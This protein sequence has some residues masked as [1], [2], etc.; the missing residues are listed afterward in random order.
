MPRKK[1]A[2]DIFNA[3]ED[4]FFSRK[5]QLF[6]LLCFGKKNFTSREAKRNIFMLLLRAV[7]ARVPRFE[8]EFRRGDGSSYDDDDDDDDADYDEHY[9]D[10]DDEAEGEDDDDYD[11]SNLKE[12]AEEKMFTTPP[13][14][15]IGMDMPASEREKKKKKKARY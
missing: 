15:Q 7:R 13:K 10:D 12:N 5:A 14:K 3:D 9:D 2:R 1:R 4:T 8:F 11:K 6:F